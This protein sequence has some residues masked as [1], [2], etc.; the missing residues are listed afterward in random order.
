M[1]RGVAGR[2]AARHGLF[3]QSPKVRRGGAGR[4][5]AGQGKDSLS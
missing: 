3:K 1:R 2:G 5:V 4:G